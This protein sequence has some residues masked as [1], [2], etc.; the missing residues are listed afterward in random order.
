M[1]HKKKIQITV[2]LAMTIL[3]PV[4]MAYELVGKATHEWAGI[5]MFLLFIFHHILNRRW[6]KN[7]IKGRYSAMRILGTVIN[8]LLFIIMISQTV[9]GIMMARHT[10]TY[11]SI[12]GGMSLARTVHLVGA[13]WAFILMSIHLGLHWNMILGVMRKAVH[14]TKPSASR[15]IVLLAAAALFSAYGLYAFIHRQIGSYMFLRNQFVFFDFNEPFIF[16]L[17]DYLAIMGLFTCLGHYVNKNLLNILRR[18]TKND[19][20]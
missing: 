1:N 14:I 3:L 9:S 10:F 5:A 18:L 8:I 19:L 7:L 2:D 16:F 20:S 11:L 15:T 6:H 12:D 17:I 13:Y 4:L